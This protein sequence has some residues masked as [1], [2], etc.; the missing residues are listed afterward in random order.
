MLQIPHQHIEHLQAI[1]IQLMRSVIVHISQHHLAGLV[2]DLED[3]VECLVILLQREVLVDCVEFLQAL[4]LH[5]EMDVFGTQLVVAF[6]FDSGTLGF[7][8]KGLEA[9]RFF[10]GG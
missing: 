1:D 6:A 8:L 4:L 2:D 9:S 3:Q 7:C 10:E 5:Q